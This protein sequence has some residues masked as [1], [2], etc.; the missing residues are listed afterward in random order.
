MKQQLQLIQTNQDHDPE[1]LSMII[2][3]FRLRLGSTGQLRKESVDYLFSHLLRSFLHTNYQYFM[4]GYDINQQSE[5]EEFNQ[6]IKVFKDLGITDNTQIYKLIPIVRRLIQHRER[7][8]NIVVQVYKIKKSFQ[9]SA[10][11]VETLLDNFS[12]HLESE[13]IGKLITKIDESRKL[14]QT[15]LGKRN[16]SK[17]ENYSRER[18][19]EQ[20][21]Y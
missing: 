19:K 1:Q 21:Q 8:R 16:L 9:K 15:Q 4:F 17:A 3:S 11:R 20:G 5:D 14:F 10:L 13:Q 6:C 7:F 18:K 2:D 12:M